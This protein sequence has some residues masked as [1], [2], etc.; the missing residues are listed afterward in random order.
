MAETRYTAKLTEHC[1]RIRFED[2]SS[3]VKGHTQFLMLDFL[4]LAPKGLFLEST[5]QI[6]GLIRKMGGKGNG[7]VIG[8]GLRTLPQY[9]ALA[10]ATASH[11]L[12]LDDIYAPASIHPG[13]AILA[14]SLAVAEWVSA[15]GKRLTEGIVAGYETSLRIADAV[16]SKEHYALGWHP[17]ATCGTFG[18]TV[19][20]SRILGLDEGKATSALGIAGSM[21][22]GSMEFL[23]DGSWT[24]RIH[25]GLAAQRGIQAALLANEGFKGPRT[26]LE[27]KWGFLRGTSRNPDPSRLVENLEGRLRILDTGIKLHACCRYSQSAIDAVLN[28][29]REYGLGPHDID[30]IRVEIF[31]A[32]FPLVVE[33]W[34]EKMDPQSDVQ[35]QFSLPYTVA[36]AIVKGRVSFE[37]FLPESLSDPRIREVMARVGVVHDPELDPA[38]PKSWPA[39]V[40]IKT[41]GG[42]HLE[43]KVDFPRGD[44]NNPLSWEELVIRFQEHSKEV[45]DPPLQERIVESLQRI[46]TLKDM[47]RFTALLGIKGGD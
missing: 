34:E 21:A 26:I 28:L 41:T 20:V 27:G 39:R 47:K 18:A 31:R 37:E 32:A 12:S 8:T 4:G 42:K 13:S 38:F 10:N 19:A 7:T 23:E 17:T 45:F 15:D 36:A 33:P 24:K 9:A 29:R 14:A 1:N 22:S 5:Q 16:G 30:T 11:S 43:N 6:H 46:H 2:L 25:P 40:K 44:V 35:A 3:E